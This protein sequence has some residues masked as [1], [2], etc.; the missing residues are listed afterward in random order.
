MHPKQKKSK[1]EEAK[2]QAQTEINRNEQKGLFTF[3][4][5][6]MISFLRT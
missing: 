1:K 4:C 3:L 2:T 5:F 6:C